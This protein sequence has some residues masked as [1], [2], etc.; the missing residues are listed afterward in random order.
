MQQLLVRAGPK[1]GGSRIEAVVA[2]AVV[3]DG[4]GRREELL[5]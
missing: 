4:S 5:A 2:G 3:N 1:R